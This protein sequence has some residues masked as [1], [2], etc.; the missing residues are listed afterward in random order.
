MKNKFKIPLV[1]SLGV[2]FGIV[3]SLTTSIPNSNNKVLKNISVFTDTL[4]LENQVQ[5]EL[6]NVDG[7]KWLIVSLDDLR[8]IVKKKRKTIV[9]DLESLFA[10][11]EVPEKINIKPIFK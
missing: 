8:Y 9:S 5:I 11:F 4:I 10:R 7:G 1:L 6:H 2:I 3:I